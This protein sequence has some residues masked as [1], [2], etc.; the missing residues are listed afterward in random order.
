MLM[1][2]KREYILWGPTTHNVI[3]SDQDVVIIL[4]NEGCVEENNKNL[5]RQLNKLCYDLTQA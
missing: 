3:V 4:S 1:E 5:V 2:N